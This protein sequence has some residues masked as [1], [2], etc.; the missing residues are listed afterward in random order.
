M[1][2]L[3]TLPAPSY[4][5]NMVDRPRHARMQ[6]EACG[7]D[8]INPSLYKL[9]MKTLSRLGIVLDE[10]EKDTFL[11]QD[12]MERLAGLAKEVHYVASE[13]V[14]DADK[15][16]EWL[17]QTR[18]E[19]L[20]SGWTTPRL[21]ETIRETVP[22]LSY[23]CHVVGSVKGLVSEDLLEKGLRV[24]NWGNSISPVVAECGLMLAIAA[25]RRVSHWTVEM[26]FRNG[27]K[28]R[29]RT[30]FG[31]LIRRRVGLHGFGAISRE[32]RRLLAPFEVS[33]STYSPSVPDELL[34]AHDVKRADS[35][36][37]LFAE[38]DVI[39]ELAALT[40]KNRG[41]VTESLLRSIPAGGVFVNIGRG[42]VVDEA[43]LARVAKDGH[44][45]IALDV[46]DKEPLAEDSPLR[47]LTNV[48]MIP[49][50]GGP[51]V[52]RRRDAAAFGIDNI[53][54]YLKGEL[55]QSE[56]TLEV[57]KRTT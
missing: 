16:L 4:A 25:L 50:L 26:H 39:F 3:G 11:P 48:L 35:L 20:L 8:F 44:I 32:L 27:W 18:P 37:A 45:Q 51:T 29:S 13:E 21:P 54:R 38:N 55:L 33:V 57:Y 24:T 22:E 30:Q 2:P 14:K 47:G 41:I 23:A 46:Y 6:G 56:V 15:W 1:S 7:R 42:A 36:E 43:A 12:L 53:E 19:V 49:H 31:S 40:P 34:R 5:A 10:W 52:D 17:K 28:E 9:K